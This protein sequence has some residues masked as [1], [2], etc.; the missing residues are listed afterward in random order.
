[1][2]DWQEV[3]TLSGPDDAGSG[4]AWRGHFF[5]AFGDIDAAR[6]MTDETLELHAVAA[7]PRDTIPNLHWIVPLM[8]DDEPLSG[9]YEVNIRNS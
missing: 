1:V 3:L 2:R 8:L 9:A 6:A 5:R 7:L 4:I